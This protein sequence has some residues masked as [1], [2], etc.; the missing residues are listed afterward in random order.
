MTLVLDSLAPIGSRRTKEVALWFVRG[1]LLFSL[2]PFVKWYAERL[3]EN[4]GSVLCLIPLS[5]LIYQLCRIESRGSIVAYLGT[6]V[7]VVLCYGHIPYLLIGLLAFGVYAYLS[8]LWSH[9]P[10]LLLGLMSLPIHSALEFYLGHPLRWICAELAIWILQFSSLPVE[11]RGVQFMLGEKVVSVDPACSGLNTLWITG[12]IVAVL[13]LLY[14]LDW[15][16]ALTLSLLSL[17]L[18]I[19]LNTLRITVLFFP[20][21]RLVAWPEWTHE[22]VGLLTFLILVSVLLS[23]ATKLD[24]SHSIRGRDKPQLRQTPGPASTLGPAFSGNGGVIREIGPAPA[25]GPAH[26]PR[27]WIYRGVLAAVFSAGLFFISNLRSGG[28]GQSGVIYPEFNLEGERLSEVL[29]SETEQQFARHFP[30]ELRCYQSHSSRLRVVV[31]N[32][33]RATRKLHPSAHCLKA[34]GFKIGTQIFVTT[35]DGQKWQSYRAT[36]KGQVLQ[37][38]EQVR[39]L[40][41]G[42]VWTDVGAWFWSASLGR[43]SG[44]WQAVTLIEG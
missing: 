5:L 9:P 44:P 20:E 1:L 43:S 22:G 38:K 24:Q 25:R 28:N 40:S 39:D 19:A 23:A 6:A 3:G 36:R 37:V 31:R 33:N 17:F 14:R 13:N 18:C 16:Q 15:R 2:F 29:L 11:L 26:R 4:D 8:K 42:E 10:L 27:L 35:E 30:G 32:V 12:L 34:D 41:S 21:S 7:T